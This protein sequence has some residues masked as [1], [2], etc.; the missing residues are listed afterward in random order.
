MHKA[1]LF[2]MRRRHAFHE[3]RKGTKIRLL[4][5]FDTKR[6]TNLRGK[7]VG[8]SSVSRASEKLHYFTEVDIYNFM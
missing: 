4:R 5:F 8:S 3:S 1:Y 6:D 2:H 7:R